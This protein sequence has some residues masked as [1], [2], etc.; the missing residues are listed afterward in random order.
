MPPLSDDKK[1]FHCIALS[2]KLKE[3]ILF[4][5]TD[6]KTGRKHLF[7]SMLKNIENILFTKGVQYVNV[8]C[9]LKL[10][11]KTIP[12]AKIDKRFEKGGANPQ[13][14]FEKVQIA[15]NFASF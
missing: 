14:T 7:L 4:K 13:H 11:L 9:S 2:K 5:K 1:A 12:A 8:Q 3:S 15:M 6:K 10:W